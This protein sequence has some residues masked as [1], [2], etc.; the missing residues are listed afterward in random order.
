MENQEGE[1]G[2]MVLDVAE[3]KPVRSATHLAALSHRLTS[4][5]LSLSEVSLPL[6]VLLLTREFQTRS[7]G[8]NHIVI[9]AIVLENLLSTAQLINQRQQCD[10]CGV[11]RVRL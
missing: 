4:L 9:R 6:F 8:R 1:A 2:Y 5:S 3:N 11:F 7:T 10:T